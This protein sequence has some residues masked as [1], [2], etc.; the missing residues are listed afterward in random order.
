[1]IGRYRHTRICRFG[2][3]RLFIGFIDHSV[4]CRLSTIELGRH[5]IQGG[6]RCRIMHLI[7]SS[8]VGL[9]DARQSDAPILGIRF[10]I[11]IAL[12]DRIEHGDTL[13]V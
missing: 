7:F 12:L 10:D 9:P 8:T 5:R 1:M 13:L 11:P 4:Q 2:T 6:Q 3:I